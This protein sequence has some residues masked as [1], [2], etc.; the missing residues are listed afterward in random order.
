MKKSAKIT[1]WVLGSL[2]VLVVGLFLGAD[3]IASRIVKREVSQTFAL[4]PDADATIG[5]VYLNLLSGSAIVKDISFSTHSLRLEDEES[6]D[7]APGIA[8]YIPTLAVWNI[9]YAELF[10]HRRLVVYKIS[11]DEPKALVYLDE[12]HP[13]SIL[14]TIPEDTTIEKAGNWLRD[15]AVSHVEVDDFSGRMRST[16]SPL[17]IA[18]DSLSVDLAS[19]NYQLSDVSHQDSAFRFD[20]S[21]YSVSI[22]SAKVETPD[23]MVAIE[24]RDFSIQPS[25]VSDQPSGESDQLFNI[26]WGYTRVQ[27][28]I[29]HTKMAEMAKEPITWIDMEL[30]SV[31]LSPFDPIKKIETEDWSL[32]RIDVDVK[33][34]HVC[35]DERY[36]PKKP[37]GTPQEFLRSLPIM[38][39]IKE[40]NALARIVDVEL[41]TTAKNCGKLHVKNSH[42]W[43][44]NVSNKPGIVWH[45][46]AK[47]PFGEKGHVDARYDFTLDKAS[48]FELSLQGEEIE[49]GDM[50]PFIRPLVGITCTCH[51]DKIEANYKGDKNT[52]KGTFGF[53]YNG[54]DV[55]VHKEDDIPYKIVTQNADLFTGL[56][57]S[58]VPKSNP[59]AVDIHPRRY[60]VEWTRDIWQP[61]PLYLFGPCIDGIKMTMLPGLY[62]H[63]QVN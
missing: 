58:L 32:D 13:E 23:G 61:Y 40:V 36:K 59:T 18:I 27:N 44:K 17:H 51:V 54:L 16:S 9:N 1:L 31:K 50:N 34:M 4:M 19:I 25:E 14:P 7:R 37:F 3:I 55:R 41:Y 20:E 8:M 29:N 10:R 45:N 39:Q 5:G 43:M 46:R 33:R 56:A 62:V 57:N 11:L 49:L 21:N 22:A 6:L 48:S 15:I 30:N 60:S 42:A 24:M 52:A 35:R 28:L 12:K 63:K 26:Q 47:A 38:F 53:L 2:A